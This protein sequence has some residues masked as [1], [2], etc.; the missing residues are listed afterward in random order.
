MTD[1]MVADWLR[2]LKWALSAMSEADRDDIVAEAQAHLDERL[3][4]GQP[5]AEALAGFGPAEAYARPFLD[6]MELTAALG[7]QRSGDLLGAV[8]RR[9]HRS[10]VA[11]GAAVVL[12]AL[13][14]VA[15][16]A[17]SAVVMKLRDPLH[18]GLWIGP[19]QPFIGTID[20]PTQ[21]REMLGLW[22][23]PLAAASLA[24]AWLLG[25]L[26]LL[27]AVRRL[28]RTG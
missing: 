3:A 21:A 23:Y 10:L 24:A 8:A 12:L 2:R 15:F 14:L 18:A 9:I 1:P 22:L 19:G 5:P 27:W 11:A 7:S 13:A 28:A 16:T 6:E 4:A 17:V 25:R 20:D 26:V